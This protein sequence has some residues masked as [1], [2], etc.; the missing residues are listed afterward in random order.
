MPKLSWIW[1]GYI[2]F[3]RGI[4]D[5]SGLM[6]RWSKIS[7][8]C[9]WEYEQ[10]EK[11]WSAPAPVRAAVAS[12]QQLLSHSEQLKPSSKSEQPSS[13]SG[14]HCS[15]PARTVSDFWALSIVFVISISL[16]NHDKQK[17]NEYNF[18]WTDFPNPV[19]YN[20]Q[21]LQTAVSSSSAMVKPNILQ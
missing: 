7:S 20:R 12:K 5:D 3:N 18:V 14:K 6:T 10:G 16:T 21:Q 17:Q 15:N 8:W 9:Y 2:N 1:K 19:M 13:L 4:E 11:V